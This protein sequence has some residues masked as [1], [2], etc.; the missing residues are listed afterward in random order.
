[1][2][3]FAQVGGTTESNPAGLMYRLTIVGEG[4][5]CEIPFE[6]EDDTTITVKKIVEEG[7][8]TE[9]EFQF[10]LNGEAFA[11]LAH[12][13][14]KTQ[15][16]EPDFYKVEE[17][18]P[19]G[20]DLTSFSCVD[21]Y[22]DVIGT[23]D[24]AWYM[25]LEEGDDVTCI[26]VN[27]EEDDEDDDTTI[28]VKKVVT[29]GSDDEVE[30]DFVLDDGE[31]VDPFAS[32]AHN[33]VSASVVVT[34]GVHTVSEIGLPDWALENVECSVDGGAFANVAF[35]EGIISLDL[36]DGDDVYCIFT[37]DEIEERYTIDGYK[38]N[39]T[40]GDGEWDEGELG[41]PNWVI[42]VS[43]GEAEFSTMTD[44]TGY[45]SFALPEGN[46]TVTEEQQSGWEQTYPD[47]EGESEG[48]C[49]AYFYEYQVPSFALVLEDDA[50]DDDY[51]YDESVECN[52]GNTPSDEDPELACTISASAS[53]VDEGDDVEI[54][55]T[56][57]LA[58]TVTLNG[59][60]V[61]LDGSQVFEDLEDN[62]T[63]TLVAT[64]LFG[65]GEGSASVECS[66]S[67]DVDGDGGGS[68]S[69]GSRTKRSSS[70]DNDPIGEV[71][72][73]TTTVLP[74]GAPD[75]GKGGASS[76]PLS[77]LVA[78]FGMLLA[79]LAVRATKHG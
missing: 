29:E 15:V 4:E 16:V 46:W 45:Y 11:T 18:V 50:A 69:S 9:T 61:A 35:P 47:P 24:G 5:D 7:S 72:G 63:Y 43:N 60:P 8:D 28:T 37:N 79:A 23:D 48:A 67:V 27:E 34:P 44:E 20:W 14:S 22:K 70:S 31:D 74:V 17:I 56:S 76:S 59:N 77:S 64:D 65:E 78:L 54:F 33:E 30:F 66:V 26:F 58:D 55:W 49:Y 52:F 51:G 42:K 12:G 10:E 6:E 73:E 68:S 39:D 62:T 75:T 57:T 19:E 3:N 21:E 53:E 2:D 36:E 1:V 40:D 25:T 71:L 32:L 41:L 13:E 38:W